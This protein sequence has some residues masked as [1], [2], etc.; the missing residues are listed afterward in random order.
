MLQN[1]P[2]WYPFAEEILRRLAAQYDDTLRDGEE[3]DDS[4]ADED[5]LAKRM[6]PAA[7][8]GH[9]L[10]ARLEEACD[11]RRSRDDRADGSETATFV[12]NGPGSQ[13]N[14]TLRLP[15]G[16]LS[17]ALRLATTFGSAETFNR[18]LVPGAIT[19]LDGID[20]HET[21]SIAKTISYGL[22]PQDWSRASCVLPKL[23]PETLI[24][25]LP[26]IRD[27]EISR[28]AADKFPRIIEECLDA[29]Y[30]VLIL[31]P[32]GL[33]LREALARCLPQPLTLAPLSREILQIHLRHSH[34]GKDAGVGDTAVEDILPPDRLLAA[35]PPVAITRALREPSARRVA[36]TLAE[37]AAPAEGPW[38][39]AMRGDCAALQAARAIA[40]DL[41][42]WSAGR[43]KW[44][45]MTRSLL[46]YGPPGTGKTW[47]AR[48][49]GNSAGVGF[50]QASLAEWQ[51]AGHLGDL[52]AAMRKSFAEAKRLRPSVLFIDEIDALGSRSDDDR[53]GRSYRSQVITGLL[54]EIDA[55][56]RDEGAILIGACNHINRLDPAILRPGRFDRHVEMRLPDADGM[57]DVLTATLDGAFPPEALRGLARAAVGRTPAALDAEIRAVRGV[58]RAEGRE[59]LIEDLAAR[60]AP[61]AAQKAADWRVA[62]HECGHAIVCAALRLGRIERMLISESGG[63][64]ARLPRAAEA[65]EQDF[66]AEIAYALAGRTAERVV[67]GSVSGGAGGSSASDLAK[68][69]RIAIA[70][71]HRLGLGRDKPTWTDAPDAILL[72]D[73]EIRRLVGIRLAQ[74]EELAAEILQRQ[75]DLLR[76]MAETLLA[77]RALRR[78]D[79]DT[80]LARVSPPVGRSSGP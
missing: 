55:L 62:V 32:S 24:V 23:S 26:E 6:T 70:I 56:M 18:C 30:P 15:H 10:I 60:L 1:P 12:R 40:R 63:E 39:E 77:E 16:L 67:F 38:L 34:P 64:I 80:W 59:L 75:E 5:P 45:E 25:L 17:Q 29:A 8:A 36:E 13:E 7:T 73:A 9:A 78:T 69:T 74:A 37:L 47:L 28:Y 21:E 46:L 11:T 65:L 27:G 51:A 43:L 68:A 79:V 76:E 41:G 71:D 33:R 49:L 52:L 72:R 31:T 42:D 50:V 14:C 20:P 53:H 57:L 22:L 48:A 44:S 3:K 2:P 4:F 19:R 58:A 35:L 61:S 66:E 54:T